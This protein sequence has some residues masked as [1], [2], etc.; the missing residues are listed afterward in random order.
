MGEGPTEIFEK[1][2]LASK[3]AVPGG[4]KWSW[5]DR[6][7]AGLVVVRAEDVQAVHGVVKAAYSHSWE[8]KDIPTGPAILQALDGGL[9]GMRVDQSL[10]SVEIDPETWVYAAFWPWGSGVNISVRVGVFMLPGSSGD[11]S[12]WNGKLRGLFEI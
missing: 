12:A 8:P 4:H 5:D 10:Y 1:V 6:F 7:E 3:A 11:L 9:G 2:V